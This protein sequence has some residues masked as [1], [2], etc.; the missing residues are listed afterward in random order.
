M[1]A[2]PAFSIIVAMDRHRGIGKDNALLWHLP[3]DMKHFRETTMGSNIIMGR[4]TWDSIGR[5]LP[6]RE[7]IVVTRQPHWQAEGAHVAASLDEA[8]MHA[9][10]TGRAHTF[11]IGGG[12]VYVEALPKASEL[13]VTEV[14]AEFGADTHFPSW[15]DAGFVEAARSPVHEDK[16]LRY[17]F[18]TYRRGGA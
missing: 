1:T 16:G 2:P 13:I 15:K 11:V 10:R 3:G 9:A 8:L 14:D 17:C 5:P 7:N 18:V 4:K 12:Q 6:G